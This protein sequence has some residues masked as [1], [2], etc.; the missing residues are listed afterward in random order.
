MEVTDKPKAN[1][2]I[3]FVSL[4]ALVAVVVIAGWRLYSQSRLLGLRPPKYDEVLSPKVSA[5][6]ASHT[7]GVANNGA[8]DSY[9]NSLHSPS[10]NYCGAE[11]YGYD[12]NYIYSL[13]TCHEYSWFYHY[14]SLPGDEN[15]IRITRSVSRGTSWSSHV[16]LSYKPGTDFE[17]TG[18]KQPREGTAY[19]EDLMEMF[20]PV[21]VPLGSFEPSPSTGQ[22]A[23]ELRERF[24]EEHADDPYPDKIDRIYASRNPKIIIGGEVED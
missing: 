21:L 12:E 10:E 3:I 14:N 11:I 22:V 1:K 7:S 2:I 17:I 13:A 6:L 16:R 23:Q 9:G 4:F 19:H 15:T 20:A 8:Y 24:R 18:Y 5:Y